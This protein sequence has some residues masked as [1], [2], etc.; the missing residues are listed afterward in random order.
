[1]T[2][3]YDEIPE[4]NTDAVDAPASVSLTWVPVKFEDVQP[5]QVIRLRY[6]ETRMSLY[7]NQPAV[8]GQVRVEQFSPVDE[9]LVLDAEYTNA[10]LKYLAT[11]YDYMDV[12]VIA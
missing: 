10:R 8:V 9:A 4:T 7:S 6:S 1:M 12:L 3:Y 5:G 2:S 11:D